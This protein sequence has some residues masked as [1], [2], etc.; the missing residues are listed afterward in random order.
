MLHRHEV[1]N[2]TLTGAVVALGRLS[3]DTMHTMMVAFRAAMT[4]PGEIAKTLPRGEQ[5]L[6]KNDR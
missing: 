6:A 4:R 5:A 1:S 3:E 2:R